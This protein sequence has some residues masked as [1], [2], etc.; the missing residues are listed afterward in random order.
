MSRRGKKHYA[1]SPF[2]SYDYGVPNLVPD[3]HDV[4]CGRG[5]NVAQHPGNERFRAL[6]NARHDENYCH[7]Y[8]TSEK[9]AVAEDIIKHLKELNPPG[10]FLKRPGRSKNSRGLEG[11]W[12][13]LSEKDS[14]K[15]TCQALRD[16]NRLDRTGYALSVSVPDDVQYFEQMRSQSGLTNKQYAEITAAKLKQDAEEAAT[17][18]KRERFPVMMLSTNE[19]IAENTGGWETAVTP[20]YASVENTTHWFKK[21]R[22][23][24]YQSSS[25]ATPLPMLTPST[26]AS[27]SSRQLQDNSMM[28]SY[29]TPHEEHNPPYSV[30][31]IQSAMEDFSQH[32][33]SAFVD[34]GFNDPFKD[35]D[36]ASKPTAE[37]AIC[38]NFVPSEL[39]PLHHITADGTMGSVGEHRFSSSSAVEH[40]YLDTNSTNIHSFLRSAGLDHDDFPPS[41]PIGETADHHHNGELSDDYV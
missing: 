9:R 5:V 23:T 8:S 12:E 27:S 11:P 40:S 38:I 4:L 3:Q 28:A 13:E 36:F 29:C 34:S 15:K 18:A 32:R 7:S 26:A 31:E 2:G 39:D 35:D 16:C 22:T 24:S 17:V 21:P 1:P 6:I 25:Y 10:R 19:S 41:S 30:Q 14:I 20:N 37:G 33:H